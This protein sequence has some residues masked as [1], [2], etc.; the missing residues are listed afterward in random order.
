MIL[1]DMQ[2]ILLLYPIHSHETSTNIIICIDNVN[3]NNMCPASVQ[4]QH[5]HNIIM[6]VQ[7]KYH[8]IEQF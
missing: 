5:Y 2:S 4:Q 6:M 8:D 3:I 7:M 1:F